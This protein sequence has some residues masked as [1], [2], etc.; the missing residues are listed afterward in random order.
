MR[1]HTSTA[2]QAPW[3]TSGRPRTSGDCHTKPP[4]Q[5][6]PH[7]N[8]SPAGEKRTHIASGQQN[9]AVARK[10]CQVASAVAS[11]SGCAIAR[12]KGRGSPCDPGLHL[13]GGGLRRWKRRRRKRRRRRRRRQQLGSATCVR[14]CVC[15]TQAARKKLTATRHR[16]ARTH[17]PPFYARTHAGA[18]IGWR[19][20]HVVWS[21][22]TQATSTHARTHL[23]HCRTSCSQEAHRDEAQA[24]THAPP[25]LLR[26]HTRWR[27][28]RLA[29]HARCVQGGTLFSLPRFEARERE[30]QVRK[31][32]K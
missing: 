10:C 19:G 22:V 32:I 8:P 3:C 24:R 31:G 29:W 4:P 23:P 13:V 25:S 27:C 16:H 14:I 9:A 21:T 28:N 7:K 11:C 18:V 15:D 6:I 26:T 5:L 2:D 20:T 12:S 1:A 17:L 30:T